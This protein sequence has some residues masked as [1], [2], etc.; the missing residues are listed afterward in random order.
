MKLADLKVRERQALE[1]CA[2]G[3]VQH[4]PG[5]SRILDR[6]TSSTSALSQ[7]WTDKTAGSVTPI[8]VFR[9]VQA[10]LGYG[11]V[12]RGEY[13]VYRPTAAGLALLEG[14]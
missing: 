2:R 4:A 6:T 1:A 7:R 11:L 14:S 12:E 8:N 9:E 3:R 13:D 5:S 10:L